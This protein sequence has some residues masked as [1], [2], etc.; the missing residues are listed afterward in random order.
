MPEY[1]Y[2]KPIPYQINA[3]EILK[4]IGERPHMLLRISIRGG[5]FPH[6]DAAAFA[7]LQ[8]G[9]RRAIEALYC[10]ID[11]DEAG[12]RAYF[13]TDVPLAGTLLVGFANDV[14]AAFELERVQLEPQKLDEGRIE[15]EFHRVRLDDLGVFKIQR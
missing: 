2:Q 14:V 13:P 9:R 1:I 11:D 3:A 12:F 8:Q 4:D 15:T 6:R 5:H 7:R 10:E